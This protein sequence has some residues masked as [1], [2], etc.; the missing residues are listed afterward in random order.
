MYKEHRKM[1]IFNNCKFIILLPAAY[2]V[3]SNPLYCQEDSLNI[4]NGNKPKIIF[5]NE[6][7][8]INSTSNSIP[9]KDSTKVAKIIFKQNLKLDSQLIELLS[10]H[11][12]KI[13]GHDFMVGDNGDNLK[14]SMGNKLEAIRKVDHAYSKR[15]TGLALMILGGVVAVV[16]IAATSTWVTHEEDNGA[17]RTTYYWI[18]GITIGAILGG[19]GYVSY[20]SVHKNLREAVDFYNSGL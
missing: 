4:S 12:Y 15:K 20:T 13:G 16:G 19:I 11:Q 17:Y 2:F 3:L 5:N 6:K 9:A 10:E 7:V 18:P 1:K 14:Q 8:E